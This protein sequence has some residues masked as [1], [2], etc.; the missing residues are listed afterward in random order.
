MRGARVP[1]DVDD[2]RREAQKLED[3]KLREEALDW[4]RFAHAITLRASAPQEAIHLLTAVITWRQQ[5]QRYAEIV[6]PYVERARALRALSRNTDAISDLRHAIDVI[7]ANRI[8]VAAPDIRDSFFGSAHDAFDELIDLYVARHDYANAFAVSEQKRA[9]VLLDRLTPRWTAAAP[10]AAR[11]EG[12]QILHYTTLPQAT[13][14]SIFDSRGTRQLLLPVSR[15]ELEAR[16]DR[17]LDAIRRGDEQEARRVARQLYD[18]LLGAAAIGGETTVVFIPDEAL[19][20]IPF[21]A[22]LDAQGRFLI[23]KA[24]VVVAPSAAM[25]LQRTAATPRHE[26]GPSLIVADPAFDT[27]RFPELARLTGATREAQRI[28]QLLRGAA[29]LSG[30]T[31][32]PARVA[33]LAQRSG[34]IHIAAHALTNPHNP[35]ASFLILA[36]GDHDNGLMHLNEINPLRLDGTRLVVLAG[37]ETATLSDGTGDLRSLAI[38][39]LAAGSE[40]VAASLWDID[41]DAAAELSIAFY[42]H[43]ASGRAPADALRFAQLDMLRSPDVR[44]HHVAAWAALQMY[45]TGL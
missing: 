22:L 39:F 42:R 11:L 1:A 44:L 43:F 45:G 12:T 13:L 40:S 4:I 17:F 19:S 15:A 35:S 10:L 31:A 30:N 2:A 7:E 6:A 28:A 5:N 41:D 32:T 36:R 38:G 16:R 14:L 34:V 27:A 26:H 9:R 37:C 21:S 33:E 25:F 29:V 3:P 20:G 24:A 18:N 8:E 23:E